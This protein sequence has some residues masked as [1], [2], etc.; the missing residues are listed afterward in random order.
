[1]RWRLRRHDGGGTDRAGT[2]DEFIEI[3]SAALT[4]VFATP[5]WL[6]D[7]GF[8]A[9]L[10][11]GVA[12]FL[13]GAIWLASITYVI[14]GPVITAAV[15]A[16]VFSPAVSWLA[17]HRVPRV[18][19]AILVLLAIIALGVLV[20]YLVLTGITSETD[21]LRDHLGDATAKIKDGLDDVGVDPSTAGNTGSDASSSATDSVDKL[22]HGVAAGID[23]LSSLLFFLAMTV[24]S[25]IFLLADGPKIRAWVERHLGVPNDVGRVVTG[26]T[27]QSLRGYFLGVTIVAA[28]NGVVVGI[29]AVI[30]GVPLAATIALVTFLG[31][32]VPYLGAW[33]AGAFSV[34]VAWGGAGTDAAVGMIVVQILANGLLQ[35]MVQPIAMGAALGIHPLAVLIVTIAGGALFGALGLILAAPLTAAA[36]RISADL[37]R[38]RAE[39]TPRDEPPAEAPAAAPG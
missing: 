21:G 1:M 33:T 32:Y 29:G 9:W 12:L 16:S 35:Q 6:R 17:R 23:K 28:F 10:L 8:T 15:I 36:T 14:V 22:L 37:A 5:A 19:S 26:R 4:G 34:L 30:L 20:V 27:L 11:V 25:L 31:A 39:S 2:A 24:L 38:A 3:D 13:V 18:V 7:I